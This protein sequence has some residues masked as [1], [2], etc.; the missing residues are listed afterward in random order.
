MLNSP[1]YY[2]VTRF[3]DNVLNSYSTEIHGPDDHVNQTR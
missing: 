3:K 2:V 1:I